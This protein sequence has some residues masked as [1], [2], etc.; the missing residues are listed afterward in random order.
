VS[1]AHL[2][3]RGILKQI[4]VDAL[5]VNIGQDHYV[6]RAHLVN[7]GILKLIHADAL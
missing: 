6:S 4:L 1:R 3:N 2:V 5:Q 7:R